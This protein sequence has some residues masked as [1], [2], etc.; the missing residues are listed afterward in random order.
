MTFNIRIDVPV[1][2]KNQWE[3]RKNAVVEYIKKENPDFIGFQEPTLHMI[4]FLSEELNEYK[5]IG[6]P[7]DSSGESTPIFYKYNQFQLQEEK[8]VWL[9]NTPFTPSKDVE[10]FFPRIAT[11]GIFKQNNAIPFIICNT[12]LDYA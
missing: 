10:S 1:D 5:I 6:S 7:R 11:Y 3:Y 2:K 9:T 4:H 8:T 12:H